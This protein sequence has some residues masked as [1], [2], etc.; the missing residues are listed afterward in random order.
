[1]RPQVWS[2][3]PAYEISDWRADYFHRGATLGARLPGAI[4]LRRSPHRSM[5]D[6]HCLRPMSRPRGRR[7]R[8]VLRAAG[9]PVDLDRYPLWGDSRV[10]QVK[11]YVRAGIRERPRALA[12]DHGAD[13][14]GDLV[15]KLV[16]E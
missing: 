11:R 5:I 14:Q 1:M 9:R 8:F 16:V 2:T 6:S 10:D 13:E 7:G 12:D 3:D 15:D 4:C